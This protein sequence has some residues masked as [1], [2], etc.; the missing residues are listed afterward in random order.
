MKKNVIR[1]KTNNNIAKK[2]EMWRGE[3]LP[4]YLIYYIL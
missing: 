3:K 2:D 1:L 4:N